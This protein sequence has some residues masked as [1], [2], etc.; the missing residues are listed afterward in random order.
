MTAL[1]SLV[2]AL[3]GCGLLTPNAHSQTRA[4]LM[5]LEPLPAAPGWT[6]NDILDAPVAQGD[7]VAAVVLANNPAIGSRQGVVV[8]TS[9]G[10][11]STRLA[12]GAVVN[13]RAFDSIVPASLRI[14]SAG[15]VLVV[16]R[17]AAG[18]RLL[19]LGPTT[20]E[21]LLSTNDAVAGAPAGQAVGLFAGI[22]LLE[23]SL[24]V[25]GTA[26]ALFSR[27]S[28]ATPPSDR[29]L[30]QLTPTRVYIR[31]GGVVGSEG[32]EQLAAL[33]LSGAGT[34]AALSNVASAASGQAIWRGTVPA[35]GF[36]TGQLLP[37]SINQSAP[38]LT[39]DAWNA[40]TA[41]I[42]LRGRVDVAGTS[43]R[44]IWTIASPGSPAVRWA[45]EG[46]ALGTLGTIIAL[47]DPAIAADGSVTAAL[48][49]TG[50][51]ISGSNDVV[52]VRAGAAGVSGGIT[53]LAREGTVLTDGSGALPG[54]EPL[55]LAAPKL[56]LAGGTVGWLGD[57]GGQQAILLASTTQT[58]RFL[59]VGQSVSSSLGAATVNMLSWPNALTGGDDGRPT[60]LT[61]SLAVARATL[62]T[63]NGSRTALVVNTFGPP[64][65]GRA[66]V[67]GANQ[68]VGPS[69]SLT[70][71]DIIVFLSW[72]FAGDLRAD[73]AG[74]NQVPTPN[75]S[76]T[77]DDII[78][79]LSAFF[80]GC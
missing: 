56:A 9:A 69:G 64:S 59:R 62:S 35:A 41:G 78:V 7:A 79:F 16:V 43:V 20:T 45:I 1:R 28:G 12:P 47:G 58:S 71:D 51:G 60:G 80:A 18:D 30:I 52:L 42:A 57:S 46:D 70:A 48:R 11:T 31:E 14:D 6:I 72:Y 39:L 37:I 44:G 24:R 74:P 67:A 26:V 27:L 55:M 29:A 77:A 13:G 15:R 21:T 36:R 17:D 25:N 22:P 54:L 38:L 66:D 23:S 8:W 5:N 34:P 65:C 10:G 50:P 4:V 49:L 61:T 76:L 40:S 32:V 53:L 2:V 75:G 68:A 63:A 73:F 19:R 33:A 3:A